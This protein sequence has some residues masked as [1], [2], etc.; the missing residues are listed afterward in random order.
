MPG[1]R[2][3]ARHTED[4][5]CKILQQPA[6]DSSKRRPG[7]HGVVWMNASTLLWCV[8]FGSIGLRFLSVRQE[9]A[10]DCSAGV[11]VDVDGVP[12]LCFGRGVV[13]GSW[14]HADGGAVFR[15]DVRLSTT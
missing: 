8:L 7:Q 9:A 13:G 5:V 12:V 11:R 1:F 2:D 3:A 10:G 14:R 15:Q 6:D 4:T